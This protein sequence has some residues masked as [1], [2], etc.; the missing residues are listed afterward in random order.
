VAIGLACVLLLTVP[1]RG[2]VPVRLVPGDYGFGPWQ[3]DAAGRPFR[4]ADPA[5]SL[6]VGP[7]VTAVEIPMRLSG[8]AAGRSALVAV[9]VP[10]SS[11]TE[12]QIGTEWTTQVVP[13]PGAE[14]L[15]PS[16]RINLVVS[17]AGAPAQAQGFSHVEIG[18]VRVVA[19]K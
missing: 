12:K 18:Q 4:E 8:D 2:V 5:A 3:T 1:F 9:I 10:G 17:V 14:V 19:R 6:F 7:A 11:R 16:Q 13:L 15:D